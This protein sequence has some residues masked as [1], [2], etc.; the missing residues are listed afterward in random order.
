LGALVDEPYETTEF[1]REAN[2]INRATTRAC[3]GR[4]SCRGDDVL[5][6]VETWEGAEI[7]PYNYTIRRIRS[8]LQAL[9]ST[10]LKKLAAKLSKD[11]GEV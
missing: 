2:A 10:F 7:T 6:R 5:T 11:S 4:G 1:D 8:D 3:T 9:L